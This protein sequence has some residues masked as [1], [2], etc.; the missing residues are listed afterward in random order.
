[1]TRPLGNADLYSPRQPRQDVRFGREIQD[2]QTFDANC[3]ADPGDPFNDLVEL[4]PHYIGALAHFSFPR[5]STMT[6]HITKKLPEHWRDQL[7]VQVVASL[8]FCARL[9][10]RADVMS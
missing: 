2:G 6:R 7:F 5:V 4:L 9:S 3:G 1:M 8:S 10:F